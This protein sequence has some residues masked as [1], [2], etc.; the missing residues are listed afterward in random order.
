[1]KTEY[2]IA[3][4]N[5]SIRSEDIEE[6]GE[7]VVMDGLCFLHKQT[8]QRWLEFIIG[9]KYDWTDES[10]N[11]LISKQTELKKTIKLYEENGI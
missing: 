6:V 11:G 4:Q 9:L 8:C 2:Q 10:I 5:I 3:K 1:M 7:C